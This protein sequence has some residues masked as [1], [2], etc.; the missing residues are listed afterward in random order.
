MK[1][2]KRAEKGDRNVCREGTMRKQRQIF[3]LYKYNGLHIAAWVICFLCVERISFL[4]KHMLLNPPDFT[5]RL[6]G[7][8]T[9]LD[10]D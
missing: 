9:L 1:K 10:K 6:A 8:Q 2:K 4:I 5:A 3:A 7:E